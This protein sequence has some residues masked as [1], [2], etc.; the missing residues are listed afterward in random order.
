MRNRCRVHG[1]AHR[2]CSPRVVSMCVGQPVDNAEY[3][4]LRVEAM[5]RNRIALK[6]VPVS[7][8]G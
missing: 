5:S 7:L 4:R 8:R 2:G 3:E 1:V 6:Q